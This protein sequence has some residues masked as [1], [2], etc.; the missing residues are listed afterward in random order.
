[1]TDR[2]CHIRKMHRCC[3]WFHCITRWPILSRLM[4][5]L[6]YSNDKER[7]RH[8]LNWLQQTH[9]FACSCCCAVIHSDFVPSIFS[10]FPIFVP[11]SKFTTSELLECISSWVMFMLF[12]LYG[13][14]PINASLLDLSG[15][16][17]WILV[18]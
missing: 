12:L 16:Y 2:L 11:V 13:Q 5:A 15:N 17:F 9:S 14:L 8:E 6:Q 3:I 1:M 10:D 7:I 18:F 4:S